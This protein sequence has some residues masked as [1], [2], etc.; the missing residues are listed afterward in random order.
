MLIRFPSNNND[1]K[2]RDRDRLFRDLIYNDDN[3]WLINHHIV[4]GFDNDDMGKT[5]CDQKVVNMFGDNIVGRI[6]GDPCLK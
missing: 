3:G 1:Q 2:I 6:F 4:F 5:Q